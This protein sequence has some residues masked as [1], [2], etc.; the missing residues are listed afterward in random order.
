MTDVAVAA[1][2]GRANK[3]VA[4]PTTPPTPVR[5]AQTLREAQPKKARPSSLHPMG[6]D[7]ELLA[8]KVAADVTFDEILQPIYW[9]SL[10]HY[11]AKDVPN[12]RADRF[13]SLIYARSETGAFKAIL[14]VIGVTLDKF[15][16]AN[17]I[18]VEPWL[19]HKRGAK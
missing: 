8:H 11:V 12:G 18:V 19:V 6:Q 3:I 14:E 17:G 13:G 1:K 16:T 2:T 7:F 4:A 10:A 15:G 9:T 5:P